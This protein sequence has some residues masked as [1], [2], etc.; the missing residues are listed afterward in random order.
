MT[1]HLS[2][3][4]PS[5]TTEELARISCPVKLIHC[6]GDIAYPVDST[7]MF[8]EVLK[9]A[10]VKVDVDLVPDGP[11]YGVVSLR[12]AGYVIPFVCNEDH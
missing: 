5:Y 3:D 11:H 6:K 12:G 4:R 7:Y 1:V 8:A 2:N 9:K 10:Q